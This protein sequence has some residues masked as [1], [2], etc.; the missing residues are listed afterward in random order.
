[1]TI[2]AEGVVAATPEAVFRFL[3]KLENHWKLAGRW[4]EVVGIDGDD[5]GAVRIHGPLGVRRTA[6]TSVVEARPDNLMRGSAELSGGT[7]ASI[8]WD[9]H[10]DAGGTL[11]RLSADVQR[12]TMP[13]R[14]MLALGGRAW[15]QRHFRSVI[16]R[17]S[18]GLS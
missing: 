1:V 2:A 10:E 6:R 12:A 4:I 13:D 7:L 15:M 5:G 16:E 11:V 17:L 3:S 18:D 9:L 8:R 14:L